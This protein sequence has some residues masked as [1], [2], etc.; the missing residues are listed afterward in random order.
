MGEVCSSS[1]LPFRVEIDTLCSWK[2]SGEQYDDRVVEVTWNTANQNWIWH[3]FRDDKEHGNHKSV[4]DNIL[5]SIQD[6]VEADQVCF[7]LFL[8]VAMDSFVLHS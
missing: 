5:E 4:V 2:A 6:G 7:S 8:T 3:R 1:C